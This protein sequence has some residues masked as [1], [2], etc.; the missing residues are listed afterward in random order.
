M[1]AVKEA[2]SKGTKNLALAMTFG[3]YHLYVINQENTALKENLALEHKIQIDE[4]RRTFAE[5]RK[6]WW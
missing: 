3:A 5:E 1:D 6:R 4:I 2:V